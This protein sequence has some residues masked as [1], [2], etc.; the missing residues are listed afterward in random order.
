MLI[1]IYVIQ[2]ELKTKFRRIIN[3]FTHLKCE[4]IMRIIIIIDENKNK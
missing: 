2:N 3:L 1:K 4:T